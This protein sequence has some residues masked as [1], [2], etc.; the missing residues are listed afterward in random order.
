MTTVPSSLSQGTPTS[1]TSIASADASRQR[2]ARAEQRS[3]LDNAI[4]YLLETHRLQSRHDVL[5][6][7][8]IGL[9]VL[10][11][12]EDVNKYGKGAVQ[13]AAEAL[14]VKANWLYETARVAKTWSAKQLVE[15]LAVCEGSN[16]PRQRTLTWSHLLAVAEESDKKKRDDLIRAVIERGLSI[17]SLRDW[18]RPAED[19]SSQEDDDSMESD[20]SASEES[21]SEE[22]G[23]DHAS[24]DAASHGNAGPAPRATFRRVLSRLGSNA[25]TTA[26][27]IESYFQQLC[28]ELNNAPLDEADALAVETAAARLEAVGDTCHSAAESLRK[29]LDCTLSAAA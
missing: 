18:M 17:R 25:E 16:K 28:P 5:H 4:E 24:H 21:G 23:S 29:A 13:K 1:T 11:L 15:F 12:M 6:R 22:S 14:D 10:Q 8:A 3:Q 26:E 7:H 2:S 19:S 20:N 27:Q 9:I